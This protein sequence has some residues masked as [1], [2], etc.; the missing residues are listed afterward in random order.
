MVAQRTRFPRHPLIHRF[1]PIADAWWNPGR[2]VGHSDC[3]GI[4]NGS[5][6]HQASGEEMNATFSPPGGLNYAATVCGVDH[7]NWQQTI[8]LMP[9]PNAWL[10][11]GPLPEAFATAPPKIPDPPPVGFLDPADYDLDCN[12]KA[13]TAKMTKVDQSFPFYYS[14]GELATHST[15]NTLSFYD[16]PNDPCYSGADPNS[17]APGAHFEFTTWLVGVDASGAVVNLPAATNWDWLSTYNGKTGGTSGAKNLGT[18]DDGSGTGGV[19]VLSVNGVSTR[20]ACATDATASVSVKRGGFVYN[21]ASGRF[22]QTVTLTN[23]SAGIISGPIVLV[24]DDL[25]GGVSLYNASGATFC[26]EPVGSPYASVTGN[27]GSGQSISFT[28][29]FTDATKAPI[30]YTSRVL[31][32]P[33]PE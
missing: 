32:G 11:K 2:W 5:V 25:P 28:L 24:A 12:G 7:F 29:Q 27:L 4:I 16:A 21:M 15:A 22:T 17:P 3:P 23:T 14:A 30:S 8:N 6:A 13:L 20:G 26:S 19:S 31:A 18:P 1:S 9:A 33:G 10:R